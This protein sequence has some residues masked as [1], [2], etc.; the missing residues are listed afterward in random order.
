[1]TIRIGEIEFKTK[2]AATA[3]VREI[4]YRYQPGDTLT[5][6]DAE[7]ML[8]VLCR[9]PEA[10]EKVGCGVSSIQ[11]EQN[12][13]TVGF[14]LTRRDGSRTDFSFVACITPPTK[15]AEAKAAMRLEIRNQIERYRESVFARRDETRCPIG[16]DT[17][18][19]ATCH[20]DHA[21][22]TFTELVRGFLT[23]EGKALRDVAV[24]P[25]TDGS[26]TTIMADRDLAARWS[27][28]HRAHAT[29][30][31]VSRAANLST[32]RRKG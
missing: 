31:T 26:T 24:L 29:L 16:G 6:S 18:T 17:I 15:E 7:F 5:D 22:P 12:G 3:A 21:S 11:V 4:L 19:K 25:T 27:E 10:D 2:K 20:V 30:R 28:Y 23:I 13:P 8:G 32:L 9:H 1:M 14:W